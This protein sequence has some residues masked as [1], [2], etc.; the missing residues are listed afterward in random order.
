ML[1]NKTKVWRHFLDIFLDLS[2]EAYT[3]WKSAA[4]KKYYFF[5]SKLHLVIY[6]PNFRKNCIIPRVGWKCFNCWNSTL[7]NLSTWKK[8]VLALGVGFLLRGVT[9]LRR[10][11][12]GEKQIYSGNLE[13]LPGIGKPGKFFGKYGIFSGHWAKI[14]YYMLSNNI[15]CTVICTPCMRCILCI[16]TLE[17]SLTPHDMKIPISNISN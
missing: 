7:V 2:Q 4:S 12:S 10:A 1:K 16:L 9:A 8:R 15:I 5:L 6:C 17:N 13:I 14:W 11:I 3:T